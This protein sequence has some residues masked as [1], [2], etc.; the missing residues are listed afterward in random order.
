M[1]LKLNPRDR[2]PIYGQIVQQIK[3]LIAGGDLSPGQQLPTVRALAEQLKVHVNTIARAYDV[4]DKD[5]VIS[6]QQG[7]GTY[8]ADRAN[9]ARLQQHRYDT[10]QAAINHTLLEA[11]SLGYTAD[12]I[13]QAFSQ[14][15]KEWR[16]TRTTTSR[17]NR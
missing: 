1:N 8:V 11:L 16:R 9:N 4:L 13:E 6:T 2:T 17:R 3:C 12:E 5:G 15:L 10:L 7:R 14:S